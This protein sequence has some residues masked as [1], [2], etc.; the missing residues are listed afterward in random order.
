MVVFR[1]LVIGLLVVAAIAYFGALA[2]LYMLQRDFQYEPEGPVTTLAAAGLAGVEAVAI[3]VGEGAVVNGWYAPPREAGRPAILFYRGNAGSFTA[4]HE[5]FAQFLADGYG[6]LSFDYRGFPGSPGAIGEAAI[7]ADS[8]AAFDWLAARGDPI[9]IWGRSLGSGPASFV[10]SR[11]EAKALLLES[12]FLSAVAVASERYWFFPIPL[13]MHDQFRVDQWLADVAEPV[14]VAHGTADTTIPF[15]HG[16]RV[17]ALLRNPAG[18]WIAP[19]A[20]HGDLW[21]RGL[22]AEHARPFFEAAMAQ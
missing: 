21:E 3:P 9:V 18:L 17:H 6:F 7:L 8:L 20:G 2:A 11:R 22:W 12:P 19:G 1:R 15:S 16:E 4:A 13:L 10:A 5:R 14:F